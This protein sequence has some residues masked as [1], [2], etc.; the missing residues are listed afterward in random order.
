[1]ELKGIYPIVP[2]PFYDD[3][4]V[5]YKSIER[6][7]DLMAGKGVHGLAI[8]GALGE[9]PKI[10]DDE[11][12]KI[13][14]LYRSHMPK[15]MHLV[16]GVR[17]P[18]TDPAKLMAEK[19]RELGAD[20]LLLGPHGIQK[21]KPL[22]EYYQQVSDAAKIPCIIHDYPAVTGITM[23]VDLITKMFET[24]ENVKYIK[25]EEPPTGA[26]IQALQKTLGKKLK[27]FGA[28]GGMYAFEELQLGAVGIMT[29]FVYAELLV[30]L[31][32][33]TQANKWDEAAELFYDFLPL[34]RWE[35]QP[36]I[37]ISLRKKLLQ[38]IGVFESAKVRH[39]G[40]DADEKTVEQMLQIIK[41][42]Q[43]KGYALKPD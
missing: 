34:N 13:I 36:G 30:Q 6:L 42:L 16:V 38:R 28:L 7:I 41:H 40:A 23:T 15:D 37:G 12:S 32:N 2:T 22:L 10:T 3:G 5:D 35:F 25:L 4:A 19:A 9:G 29:G 17:A 33:L 21:D 26:K 20:A 31:Y 43:K 24:A 14:S 27:V 8:M 39:P 11:R 18:A 1:M